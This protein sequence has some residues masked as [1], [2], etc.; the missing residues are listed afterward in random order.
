MLKT[1]GGV[2]KFE[3]THAD[4]GKVTHKTYVCI[5]RGGGSKVSKFPCTNQ[6]GDPY[7]DSNR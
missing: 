5:Q 4:L 7:V 1:N 3:N 6:V 2:D